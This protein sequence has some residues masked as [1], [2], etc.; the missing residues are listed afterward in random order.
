M[1]KC[2]ANH[3]ILLLQSKII[4]NTNKYVNA[5]H[6]K[7]INCFSTRPRVTVG[8][9]EKRQSATLTYFMTSTGTPLL[10]FGAMY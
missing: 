1:R 9:S 3:V 6:L 4:S 10:C 7:L 8:H 5:N 2:R